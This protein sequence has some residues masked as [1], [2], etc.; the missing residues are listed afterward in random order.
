MKARLMMAALDWNGQVR[1][2]VTDSEGNTKLDTTYSKRTAKWVPRKRYVVK[3]THIGKVLQRVVEVKHE[4]VML[5]PIIKPHNLKT[6]AKTPKP[7]N[8]AMCSRF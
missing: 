3:K 8:V 4:R 5:P 1:E 6:I 2:E 7:D